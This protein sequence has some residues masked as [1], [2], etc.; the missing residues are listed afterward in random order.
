MCSITRMT[1]L[2]FTPHSAAHKRIQY[3]VQDGTFLSLLKWALR[4]IIA[5]FACLTCCA[6][7]DQSDQGCT[8]LRSWVRRA[9]KRVL[10][11]PHTTRPLESYRMIPTALYEYMQLG[12]PG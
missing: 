9:E 12:V 7:G 1:Y 6:R 8:T 5:N 3:L 11:A 4:F 10:G 2:L